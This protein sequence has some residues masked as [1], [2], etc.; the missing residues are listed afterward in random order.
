MTCAHHLRLGLLCDPVA[1][2]VVCGVAVT[3]ALSTGAARMLADRHYV[4]DVVSGAAL[5]FGA[6]LVL[7]LLRHYRETEHASSEAGETRWTVTPV[8]AGREG[9]GLAAM[10]WF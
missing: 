10:G 3:A 4:S 1:D 5:G 2:G 6:G 7:P 9:V 8:T